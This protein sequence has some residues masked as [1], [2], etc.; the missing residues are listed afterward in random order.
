[1]RE[2][3]RLDDETWQTEADM[4]ALYIFVSEAIYNLKFLYRIHFK[5][6]LI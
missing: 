1:M 5:L 6:L 2:G 4:A 3:K